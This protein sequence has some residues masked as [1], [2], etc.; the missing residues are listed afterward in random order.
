MY[1]NV[2][3]QST[4]CTMWNVC[5]KMVKWSVFRVI[6][7]RKR[8]ASSYWLR[9]CMSLGACTVYLL[10]STYL[11]SPS[12]RNNVVDDDN[13]NN[14]EKSWSCLDVGGS[15]RKNCRC[16]WMG[17]K[18]EPLGKRYRGCMWCNENRIVAEA[19][20]H[21]KGFFLDLLLLFIECRLYPKRFLPEGNSLLF[22]LVKAKKW[23]YEKGKKRKMNRVLLK[24]IIF[25][26][27]LHLCYTLVK[28]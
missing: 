23:R 13:N 21:F 11:Y 24:Q 14:G 7:S 28:I 6:T 18:S 15:T 3:P 5:S 22:F 27:L 1:K 10:V 19:E 4:F 12:V 2:S 25:H 16:Y 9:T 17:D 26:Q 8:A 20:Q